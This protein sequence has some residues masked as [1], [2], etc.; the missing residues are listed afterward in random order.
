MLWNSM[1]LLEMGCVFDDVEFLPQAIKT[2]RS[3]NTRQL[4][5]MYVA[6]VS[7][8]AYGFITGYAVSS[9]PSFWGTR[10]HLF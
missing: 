4:S 10:L 6:F 9:F 5:P 1:E 2:I 8:V 7:G 3:K